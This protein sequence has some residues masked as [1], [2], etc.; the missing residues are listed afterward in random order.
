M[1]D[2]TPPTFCPVCD[3]PVS[4]C[5]CGH[6]QPAATEIERLRQRLAAAEKEIATLVLLLPVLSA[7]VGWKDRAKEL[8]L[9]NPTASAADIL[10]TLL[11]EEARDE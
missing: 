2:R 7:M 10:D 3:E 6:G 1:S 5:D 4:L 9:H 11:M 8:M